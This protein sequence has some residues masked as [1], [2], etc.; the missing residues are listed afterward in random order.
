MASP[1]LSLGALPLTLLIAGLP[2][3]FLATGLRFMPM[4]LW[5]DPE[6]SRKR[7]GGWWG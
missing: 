7:G 1:T 4:V 5:G 3:A 2:L 6:H